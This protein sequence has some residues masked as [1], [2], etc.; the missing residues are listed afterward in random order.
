MIIGVRVSLIF[1]LLLILLVLLLGGCASAPPA[2]IVQMRDVTVRVPPDLLS[3][4]GAPVVPYATEQSQVA[5]YIVSLHEA[6]SSCYR[7][8]GAVKEF[9]GAHGVP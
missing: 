8:L 2:P 4:A 6:W 1:W 7:K 9:E 3:C 5:D